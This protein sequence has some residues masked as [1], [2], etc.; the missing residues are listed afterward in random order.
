MIKFFNLFVI[1]SLA[2]IFCHGKSIEYKNNKIKR[3]D[4]YSHIKAVFDG[5]SSIKGKVEM[6]VGDIKE[7]NLKVYNEDK[8]DDVVPESDLTIKSV[9][10]TPSLS[11]EK[12]L[13]I[14]YDEEKKV[15]RITA[16][17]EG[18]CSTTIKYKINYEVK[19]LSLTSEDSESHGPN[20]FVVSK[21]GGSS[22]DNTSDGISFKKH[23][24]L[25]LYA[26][27]MLYALFV[28]F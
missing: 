1:L 26:L 3:Y 15:L 25:G 11:D 14:V 4:A 19:S 13:E 2:F 18:Q 16:K 6:N 24:T 27:V 8:E 20:N 21:A 22:S 28:L 10:V 12:V 9:E 23:Y 5:V 17:A 7:Y